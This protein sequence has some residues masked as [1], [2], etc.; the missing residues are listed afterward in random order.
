VTDSPT[1]FW[2]EVLAEK[3]WP[4]L[5]D[6]RL[7]ALLDFPE[8]FLASH[9]REAAYRERHWR[10]EFSRGEW[11]IM[12]ADDLDVGLLGVTRLPD[13]SLRHCY[14]EYLW[15]APGVRRHGVASMLL[16]RVL[17]R[18]RD[19]G[20]HTVELYILDGNDRARRLYQRFGF[21]STNERQPIPGHPAGNEEKMRL[22]LSSP[23]S[24]G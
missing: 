10:Q 17:D 22:R 19:S 12:L 13:T 11:H 23:Q 18:L 14:L 20:V 3:D 8:G 9:D 16:R 21:Q 15:V 6:I 24:L 5:R 7:C 1:S 4:R 2:V